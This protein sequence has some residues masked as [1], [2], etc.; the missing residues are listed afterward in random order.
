MTA[1]RSTAAVTIAVLLGAALGG[2][3][4][5]SFLGHGH[6]ESHA[7]GET[8][9]EHDL[10][11]HDHGE[12]GTVRIL[13]RTLDALGVKTA[14]PRKGRLPDGSR[15]P[16][17]VAFAPSRVAHVAPVITGTAREVLVGLGDRVAAGQALAVIESPE[18]GQA[19]SDYLD[20]FQSRLLAQSDAER[21]ATVHG[22]TSKLLAVLATDPAAANLERDTLDL[23]VGEN[24]ARLL[25][26]YGVRAA[27]R[28]SRD[29][30][31]DLL[32]KRIASDQDYL[33]AQ[34]A[35][36][37][38]EADYRGAVE[39]VTFASESAQVAAQTRLHIADAALR[40][41]ERHLHILGLNEEQVQKLSTGGDPA[42]SR[43]ELRAPIAGT[44]VAQHLTVG[45]RI[46]PDQP[47]ITVADA[48][49]VW[50]TARAFEHDLRL[51]RKDAAVEATLTAFPGRRFRGVV[52]AV[53]GILDPRTRTAE[54]QVEVENAD[55][56]LRPGM[57]GTVMLTASEETTPAD[58]LP[59]AAVQ[60][61][62]G[63]KVVFVLRNDAP[64]DGERVFA[65]V[66]VVV[67]RRW[68]GDV[69][70]L[71]GLEGVMQVAVAGTFVLKA[72]LGKAEAAESHDH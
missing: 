57:F 70:V 40:A 3:A 55:A 60:D 50:I 36:E 7:H 31:R 2:V 13:A 43:Y 27:A 62:G 37:S 59:E 47:P 10:D 29:R 11:G 45:E 51:A 19:K 1:I 52:R 24:K 6:D 33:D 30:T 17:E 61:V 42:L 65:A 22:N 46:T 38:A 64:P 35:L 26:T 32:A 44:V 56:A 72:E 34:R 5:W 39:S 9:V 4:T 41:A 67:G 18:F 71:S 28:T 63:R 12:P 48:S 14:A 20:K 15:L 69:E 58:L 53:G 49:I 25:Q 16:G 23:K 68:G 66:P 21:A 8:D 54:V